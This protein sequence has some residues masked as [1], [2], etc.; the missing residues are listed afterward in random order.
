MSSSNESSANN[1]DMA[2][3]PP[4][5]KLTP[6]EEAEARRREDRLYADLKVQSLFDLPPDERYHKI[7]SMSVG[8][9]IAFADSLRGAKG[10]EF[11]AGMNPRQKET[12]MA[13]NN[14]RV[15][16]VQELSQAKLLRAIYSERQLEEVMTDFWFN[17]FNVFAGKGDRKSTRL[18]SSHIPLS[19][20]PSS[21]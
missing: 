6:A 15:V 19:R 20:M 1:N 16:V 14:P 5:E 4:E 18:N 11:L 13:M 2:T 9:Q 3:P 10:M 8:E 7:L 21:A 12:V 17:H